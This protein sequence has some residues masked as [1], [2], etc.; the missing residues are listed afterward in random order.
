[1]PNRFARI[2]LGTVAG[3]AAV[4]LLTWLRLALVPA[5]GTDMALTL[6]V[7]PVLLAAILGGFVP[8]I[9]IMLLALV[10]GIGFVIGPAGFVNSWVEWIRVG[11]FLME[12]IAISFFVDRLQVRTKML[13]QTVESL[14]EERS[15]IERLAL[16]DAMTGLGN[17]RA[18]EQD[19]DR[20]IAQSLR[21]S[22][23]LT[24]ASADIDELKRANDEQGHK[25]GDALIIAVAEALLATCRAS[26][27][28]YRLG[29]DEFA[30]LLPGAELTDFETFRRRLTDRLERAAPPLVPRVS[31]GAAHMPLDGTGHHELMRIADA[32]MYSSKQSGRGSSHSLDGSPAEEEDVD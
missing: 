3:A 31:V 15:A 5:L 14:A 24:I 2:G 18:F 25:A 28:A 32:R 26:D 29:G 4:V 10:V 6:Y 11:I 17:W 21:E 19:F 12:G 9:V 30:V 1:M 16:E 20:A 13:Q 7:L 23:P 8:G 22:I 27:S